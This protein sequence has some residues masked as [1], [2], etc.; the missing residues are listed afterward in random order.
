MYPSAYHFYRANLDPIEQANHF[1]HIIMPVSQGQLQPAFDI[2]EISL[3]GWNGTPHQL[4]DDIASFL[5]EV[6]TLTGKDCIIYTDISFWRDQLENTVQFSSH[7]PLWLADWNASLTP[8][9]VGGWKFQ[10]FRQY[11]DN[12]HVPGI[13]GPV[14]LDRFFGGERQLRKFAGYA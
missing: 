12:G 2:E 10:S 4:R 8:R 9:L 14:D 1:A 7:Y 11:S 6:N 5:T 13:N 3:E